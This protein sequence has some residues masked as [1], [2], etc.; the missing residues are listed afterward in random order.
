MIEATTPGHVVNHDGYTAF[1][2]DG[3]GHVTV[4]D[5]AEWEHMVE[6]GHLD[7]VR[8]YTTEAAHHGVAVATEAGELL[9]TI[10]TEESRSGAMLLDANDEVIVSTE[11]CPGV[12]G[13]TA[14]TNASD[15]ELIM[16]G[17]EDGAVV[18]HGDHV[19]KA[20]RRRRVRPLRQPVL[21]RGFRRGPRRLQDRPRG[22]P[23][24][25]RGHEHRRRD[26]HPRR[27]VRW[28]GRPVHLPR[29]GPW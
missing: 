26:H 9:V 18:F 20:R 19:H 21:G 22:H 11:E 17:C 10:G 23:H 6:E 12:H 5:S 28:L 13:E 15:E 27:P 8:E 2:D 24:P 14:F 16:V 25:G 29:P 3:T 4:V 7:L 1:F